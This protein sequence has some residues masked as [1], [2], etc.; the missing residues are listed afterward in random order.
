MP[1]PIGA[2][3]PRPE[4][5]D[6][7]HPEARVFVEEFDRKSPIVDSCDIRCCNGSHNGE[8]NVDESAGT[9]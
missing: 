3:A 4:N 9:N 8:G 1:E 5:G 2:A 7:S 6:R